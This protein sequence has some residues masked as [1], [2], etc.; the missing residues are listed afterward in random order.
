MAAIINTNISSLNA[1]RNLNTSQT[2]LATSLQRLSTGLSI[3]RAKDDAAGLAISD[4]MKRKINGLDQAARNAYDGISLSQT[5][6]GALSSF[7]DNLQRMRHLA[8]QSANSTNSATDRSA[9]NAEEQTALAEIS[10]VASTTQ[11][12]GLNLLD[13][14][15]QSS[16]FQVGANANQ[17]ISVGIAGVTTDQLGSYQGVSAAVTSTAFGGST[18][19]INGTTIGASAGATAAGFT[20]GSAAAKA[21]AINASASTTGDTAPAS[22]ALTSS[23]APVAATSLGN[24]ALTINGIAVGAIAAGTTA[25]G[26]GHFFVLVFF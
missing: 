14:S 13:G 1:Q 16:Q 12:N 6:E 10:R 9:L 18:L 17:T 3:N 15:F 5:A 22:T 23:V 7:C 26:F 25:V 24:G 11:F 19:K 20:S 2:S 4:R 21:A 8:L